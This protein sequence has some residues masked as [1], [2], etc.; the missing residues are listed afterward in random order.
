[1]V[2]S[3]SRVHS[4]VL[5]W[6]GP[7]LALPHPLF[8]AALNGTLMSLYHC[9]LWDTCISM[10]STCFSWLQPLV[11]RTWMTARLSCLDG[12]CTLNTSTLFPFALMHPLCCSLILPLVCHVA[13]ISSR[14]TENGFYLKNLNVLEITWLVAY[15]SC[16][17]IFTFSYVLPVTRLCICWFICDHIYEWVEV[18]KQ[19]CFPNCWMLEL[20]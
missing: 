10:L 5:Q 13:A 15:L 19:L 12:L 3:F 20:I 17:V 16:S 2:E 7:G 4:C 6:H 1:V 18:M 14:S 8:T 11:L 9:R